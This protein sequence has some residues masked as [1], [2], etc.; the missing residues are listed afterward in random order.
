MEVEFLSHM[1]YNLFTSKEEWDQWHK[2]LANFSDFFDKVSTHTY[3]TS[4]QRLLNRLPSLQL[5]IAMPSPPYSNN[6]SP[7]YALS[8][9]PSGTPYGTM[10]AVLPSMHSN[11]VSP[12]SSLPDVDIRWN[13]RKRSYDDAAQGAQEPQSKRAYIYNPYQNSEA[14]SMGVS[15]PHLV[16]SNA[17]VGLP[18]PVLPVPVGQTIYSQAPM[19]GP[20]SIPNHRPVSMTSLPPFQWSNSAHMQPLLPLPQTTSRLNPQAV[21]RLPPYKN[22]SAI[23]SPVAPIMPSTAAHTTSQNQLSPSYFL[24]R[25][26]SPYR[27]VRN[28]STLTVPASA[29][30]FNHQ[31]QHVSYDQM[32]WQPLGKNQNDVRTGRV[33]YLHREAWPQTDQV[34]NWPSQYAGDI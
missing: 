13:A 28:I 24:T 32:H 19:I 3:Q 33:P 23:P 30:R 16:P 21:K 31:P 4:P 22:S 7:P 34:E 20:T 12:A 5:P 25:R 26:T 18:M 11:H 2:Q 1:K 15:T 8:N 27:P 14:L 9:S 6:A 10:S 17:V 29:G